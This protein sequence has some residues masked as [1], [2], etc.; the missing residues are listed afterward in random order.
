M[1]NTITKMRRLLSFI[2]V[3]LLSTACALAEEAGLT[4]FTTTDMEGN[5]VTE[6]IFSSYDLTMV[7]I[8]ATWC[9]YCIEEM[10]AL[11]ELKEM[12]PENVNLITI[13]DDASYEDALTKE[14]LS[15]SGANFQTLKPT[16]AIYE[17][18]LSN[19]YAFPTTYFLDS[20]GVSVMQPTTG[21]PS[22]DNAAEAY[23]AI[24][25]QA[26]ALLEE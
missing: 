6:E 26:L 23:Y 1:N 18:L 2:L 22:L 16:E 13:C 20:R 7:N 11:A 24:I 12:L 5:Q 17:Q 25:T 10:P 14:I 15:S 3:F 21:V 4:N 9:G 8:W 19:V